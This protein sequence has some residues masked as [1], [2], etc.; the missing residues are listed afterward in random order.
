MANIKK[1]NEELKR[2][3]HKSELVKAKD[4]FYFMGDEA[5]FFETQGVYVPRIGD[6]S[7][8]GWVYEFEQKVLEAAKF[9]DSPVL[10]DAVARFEQV[11][12]H[13]ALAAI[14]TRKGK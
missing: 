8:D 12:C 9:N 5:D 10:T 1:V 13:A 4:Y 14:A 3:G 6:L 7:L 11:D 2:L